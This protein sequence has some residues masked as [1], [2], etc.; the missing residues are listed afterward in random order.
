MTEVALADARYISRYAEETV[1]LIIARGDTPRDA[2][3]NDVAVVV[4]NEAGTT[5]ASGEATRTALGTYTFDI[6][7][8]MTEAEGHYTIN[9]A[10]TVDGTPD[11]Y[12]LPYV[13]GGVSPA[14]DALAPGFKDIVEAVWVRFAD[15]YDS[16]FGGPHL[17]VY[18]QSHFGRN[19]LAQLLRMSI[20]RL[21]T[22][23][24]P[25]TT[26]GLEYEF[27]FASW[28][29]LLEQALYVE[30]IKHLIRSYTEVPDVSLGASIARFDRSTYQ[31]RWQTV[32]TMEQEDLTLMMD[33]FKMAHMGLGSVH[34]L[35]S[36]GAFGRFGPTVPGVGSG[37]AA[38]RGYL[39]VRRSF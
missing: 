25:H 34:V 23:A 26:Y 31:S 10:Y 35:V 30:V 20:G 32:L 21:N 1:G 29:A 22:V 27:P 33:N 13:V 15:L 17:Q 18:L 24:Q 9:F 16:P 5:I 2:D 7:G 12:S 4:K 38:A 3:G 19:R 11:S 28:G 8:L 14:Y 6:G 37:Q 36:G 39:T